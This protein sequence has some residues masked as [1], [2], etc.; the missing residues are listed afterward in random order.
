MEGFTRDMEGVFVWEEAGEEAGELEE[1]AAD[2]EGRKLVLESSKLRK[3]SKLSWRKGDGLSRFA[4]SDI[5]NR[6][7]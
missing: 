7:N 2:G 6:H 5:V 3:A 4:E 1:M